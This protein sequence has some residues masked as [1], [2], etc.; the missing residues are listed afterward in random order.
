MTEIEKSRFFRYA[1]RRFM[2]LGPAHL[3]RALVST[4]KRLIDDTLMDEEAFWELYR[5]LSK[6]NN[7][8]EPHILAFLATCNLSERT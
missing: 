4:K 7:W 6:T 1:L 3:K 2:S 8:D 5:D